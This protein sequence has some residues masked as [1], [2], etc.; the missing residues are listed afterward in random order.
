MQRIVNTSFYTEEKTADCILEM[1][2]YILI[3]DNCYYLL[4]QHIR[5][6]DVILVVQCFNSIL[7]KSVLKESLI[8]VM[9][10]VK[11]F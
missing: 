1:N 5:Y 6:N 10:N 3:N 7:N 8:K 4:E 11:Q 2:K 9:Q